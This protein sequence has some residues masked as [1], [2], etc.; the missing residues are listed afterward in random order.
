MKHPETWQAIRELMAF[1]NKAP[2]LTPA[3]Q[4]TPR[5]L[6]FP[7]ERLWFLQQLYPSSTAFHLPHLFHLHGSLDVPALEQS[8]NALRLRHTILRT[9]FTVDD[10]Q[11]PTQAVQAFAQIGLSKVTVAELSVDDQEAEVANWIA[12][13]IQQPFVLHEEP[14]MRA[15]LLARHEHEHLLLLVFHHIVYD[16]WSQSVLLSELQAFYNGFLQGE[17]PNLPALPIQYADFAAWQHSWLGNE[18]NRAPL[19][20]YWQERLE[21]FSPLLLPIVDQLTHRDDKSVGS[22]PLALTAAMTEALKALAK[23]EEETLYTTLCAAFYV[24]L[25]RYT[26]QLDISIS[27]LMASRARPELE[28]LIGNFVNLLILR[29]DLSGNPTF[30]DVISRVRQTMAGAIQHQDLPIQFLSST[31]QLSQVVFALRNT[32]RHELVLPG[33]SS[34]LD[35]LPSVHADFYLFFDLV[36]RK[37]AEGVMITGPIIY[38]RDCFGDA[39]ITQLLVDF[40]QLLTLVV[41]NPETRIDD[42]PRF[43]WPQRIPQP[44][45][46]A[47]NRQMRNVAGRS[48]G[49][50]GAQ[51]QTTMEER[52]AAIWQKALGVAQVDIH[53]TFFELG[54]NSLLLM[55]VHQQLR[56][57]VPQAI[58]PV[59]L[60]QYSTIHLL[61]KY[62]NEQRLDDARASTSAHEGQP[63]IVAPAYVQ[64]GHERA[65]RQR[66]ARQQLKRSRKEPLG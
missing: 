43:V 24:L 26:N 9:I 37:T 64:A 47:T 19:V 49:P 8:L 38:N 56:A 16:F 14:G 66:A 53:A 10:Q 61:G 62:L 28:S 63:N 54:G 23:Q 42:L 32:P 59:H 3:T 35:V 39:T 1:R 58:T 65:E 57:I 7:Q 12:M 5:P 33:L 17:E 34:Q 60:L 13:G 44:E 22:Q 15:C 36:E 27:G 4:D 2:A 55:H 45:G 40:D 18:T 29:T 6:S 50:E 20:A 51:P 21:G 31:I 11:R 30:R 25:Q 46:K 41:A 48:V 52:I